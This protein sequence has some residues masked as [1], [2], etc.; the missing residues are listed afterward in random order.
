M[1]VQNLATVFAPNILRPK[2][3]D[4]IA[5]IQDASLIQHLMTVLIREN[6]RLFPAVISHTPICVSGQ[7]GGSAEWIPTDSGAEQQ[8]TLPDPHPPETAL[9][10]SSVRNPEQTPAKFQTWASWKSSFRSSSTKQ[11]SSSSD[12]PNLP[13][14]GAWLL[15]GLSSLRGHRR[16]SS[17]ER[18]SA[19]AQRLSTY[20][21]V[22]PCPPS[23]PSSTWPSS[24]NLSLADSV[25]SCSAC[26]GSHV[27][28]ASVSPSH[29]D[30]GTLRLA[31]SAERLELCVSSSEHSDATTSASGHAW[32][33][34]H[35]MVTEL[36]EELGK[37]R[38]EYEDRIQSLERARA[39]MR[40]RVSCLQEALDQENKRNA[41]LEIKLRNS[42][43]ARE[44][45][46]LRNSLLQRE[47][48]EF[49]QTLGSVT[50]AR[51]ANQAE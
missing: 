38:G 39:E 26:R 3:Q 16:T 20:D 11:G 45:A 40:L 23:L 17:G 22:L 47:M 27:S 8:L 13:S 19:T 37:Q 48:E 10:V 42:E 34:C 46:E 28:Q 7:Q 15:S 5:L 18:D 35:R 43:R 12:L 21:N 30:R 33:T 51:A 25:G 44:G 2:L 49:F 41:L 1:S 24:C 31:G 6:Q 4:P 9:P 14:S 36:K 32:E 50:Q 29:S